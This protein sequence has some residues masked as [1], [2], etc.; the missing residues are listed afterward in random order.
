MKKSIVICLLILLLPVFSAG[1][2]A[3]AAQQ[4]EDPERLFNRLAAAKEDADRIRI[5]DS[6][7]TYIEGYV[8]SDSVM[9]HRFSA[10]R[11]L[12]QVIAPDS[13][14]KIITW[15]LP[16]KEV[17]GHYFCYLIRKEE[18]GEPFKIFSQEA[19][20]SP[21]SIRT[22]TTYSSENWYG[23][24]YYDVRKA[25]DSDNSWVLLGIDYGN[26]R[27]TRKVIDVV[28]FTENDVPVFGKKVFSP[29]PDSLL[30]RAV[31]SYSTEAVMSLRFLSG[32]TVVFDHL[33]SFSQA[34][35]NNPE[36][37]APDYSYDAYIKEEGIWKLKNSIDVRNS[38]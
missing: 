34:D 17:P 33:V 23:A 19:L 9:D 14:L 29:L 27:I 7:K 32:D 8:R 24:L 4:T 37:F 12:G 25:G 2:S 18:K 22:D 26:P 21:G 1:T 13:S 5:N 36:F 6:I 30:F 15:N 11:Y 3:A 10:I 38:E 28:S 31:F 16:L 35:G 20:Y